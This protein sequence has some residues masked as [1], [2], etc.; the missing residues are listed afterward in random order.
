MRYQVIVNGNAVATM[1]TVE[2]A[3]A[4]VCTV[5]LNDREA[6]VDIVDTAVGLP[7]DRHAIAAWCHNDG[8]F[9]ASKPS[10]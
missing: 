4:F 10:A 8:A 9:H 2:A 1:D 7:F 6:T 3:L 5:L